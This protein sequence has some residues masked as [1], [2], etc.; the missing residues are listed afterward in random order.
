MNSPYSALDRRQLVRAAAW[1]V[2][3]VALASASPAFAQSGR[4]D[5]W[6]TAREANETRD[7][8]HLDYDYYQGPRD[9]TFTYR[10]GNRGTIT[11]PAGASVT[12]GLPFAAA[13][14]VASMEVVPTAGNRA[15]VAAGTSQVTVATEPNMVRQLWHFTLGGAIGVNQE[16]EITFKVRLN[17]TS[18]TATNFYRA[19]NW[20][21]ITTGAA[22]VQDSNASNNSDFTQKYFFYNNENAGTTGGSSGGTDG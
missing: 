19:R 7:G 13:W 4:V 21:N 18:N 17:T 8:V 3:A 15:P 16:F 1:S 22:D 5:L 9:L 2:P 6:S 10:F 11:M 20:A 12:I 14:N